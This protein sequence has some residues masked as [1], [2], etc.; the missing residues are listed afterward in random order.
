MSDDL[1]EISFSLGSGDNLGR[2][3]NT[4]E[5]FK[6]FKDRFREPHVTPEKYREYKAASDKRQR[7]LKGSAGWMMRGPVEKG[8]NRNR[9]SILPS[10]I[11]T[12]DIDYATPEFV[13][14][15]KGGDILR[16]YEMIA[17]STRSHT[18]EN[19]RLRLIIFLAGK[20]SRDRYQAASRITAQLADPNMEWVDKVSFRPAQMMYMP[21]VSKDMEKHYIY[22]EQSGDLL[23][24]EEIIETWEMTNGSASD[25]GNLPRAQG[26]D[27]LRQAAEKA[28]DPLSK[29]GPV[30]DFCRA[31]T[32]TELVT[33]KDGEPGILA[34]VYEP[35]EWA[36]GAISRMTYLGGTTSNGAVV[37]DDLFVYSH[38]GSDPV[39]EQLVNAYDL[40][41]L[42][43]F[44]NEDKDAESDTPVSKLPSSKAMIDFLR[45]DA[46]YK[47]AQAESRY[48]LDAMLTDDDVE[49]QADDEEIDE[50][51]EA[52]I[53]DL[54][55]APSE[56]VGKQRVGRH[57]RRRQA[58]KPPSKW[59]A[60][61]LTL[62][63]DGLIRATTHN[64]GTICMNDPRLWRKIAYNEFSDDVVITDDIKTKTKLIPDFKCKDRVNGDRW[65]DYHETVIRAIISAPTSKGGYELEVAMDKVRQGVEL[66]ARTNQFHPVREFLLQCNED[67][68]EDEEDI[69]TILIDYFGAEDNAYTRQIS[70]LM[71]IASVAR[72]FEPGC[73]FDF[74][75]ILEGDQ[76]IGKSTG[77]KRLYGEHYFGEIDANLSNRQEIA[78]QTGG[79]WC[80]ELPELSSLH[81][82][83]AND[84]KAFMSRQHDDVRKSYGRAPTELPRQF[85]LW[86]TTNDTKYLRD[87]TGG[88]RFWPCPCDSSYV[89]TVGIMRARTRLWALAY[90]AYVEMREKAGNAPDLPLFVT[91]KA[92]E[93]AKTLQERARKRE[94]WENWLEQV[95]DWIDDQMPLQS[96][97]ALN[98]ID[99]KHM[100]DETYKG[101]SLESTVCRVAFHQQEA[102][103]EAF[104]LHGNV[105]SNAQTDQFWERVTTALTAK[106]WE[107]GRIRIGGRQRT[108]LIRPDATLD[109]RARGFRVC[110]PA[111]AHESGSTQVADDNDG[112]ALL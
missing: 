28:E 84:I 62:T 104:G 1:K 109:E 15:L 82:G 103:R 16:G 22:Y 19:P 26:E 25:I 41:R 70:R 83:E 67:H 105:P 112:E 65:Q 73:K 35:V 24:H 72:V 57:H 46:H 108:W 85:V 87:T 98:D 47:V 45:S 97:V 60:K 8:K 5:T 50:D 36:Q 106:G 2:S 37:Y 51:E 99:E 64:I 3:R 7:T 20:V 52:E 74:A 21:T 17:H 9:N 55:G 78:E 88:R 54:L 34:D 39:Q 68:P 44:G 58:E 77:I 89:D 102:F 80:G 63:D 10:Q 94:P 12:L 33:G 40:V 91:G 79:M 59:I 13:E 86:G 49:Y 14:L 11:I 56:S 101:V 38:H 71:M 53:D 95:E 27:E 76:G 96:F 18:P 93:I 29:S 110:E 90:R 43:L 42:H 100:L 111:Q 32:I 92:A 69:D 6:K 31:Y 66:A 107:Y 61:E 23:D 81:K 48:D 4:T 75:L 30:G